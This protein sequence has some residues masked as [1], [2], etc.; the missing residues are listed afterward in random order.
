MPRLFENSRRP[1]HVSSGHILAVLEKSRRYRSLCPDHIS[2]CDLYPLAV[3]RR[4]LR[5]LSAVL[6][7]LNGEIAS[8]EVEFELW[9]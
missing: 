8:G 3:L 4:P 5:L 7:E 2:S 1:R 9:R 6:R